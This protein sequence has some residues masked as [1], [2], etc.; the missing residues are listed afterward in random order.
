LLVLIACLSVL[1]KASWAQGATKATDPKSVVLK[2]GN[3]V[4][5][6]VQSNRHVRKV[7]IELPPGSRDGERLPVVFGFHGDGGPAEAYNQRLSP[8][9][10]KH[11][12]ISVSP[13]GETMSKDPNEGSITFFNFIPEKKDWA[14]Q[15][16]DDLGL[17]RQILELLDVHE[18]SNPH[19]IYA[20]G[21]SA[22]GHM[23]NMLAKETDIF[24]AIAPTKC[25][26]VKGM[27]EP[28]E[29]NKR[30][31][32]FWV[33][34]DQ[35][36]SFNGGGSSEFVNLPVSAR[37]ELWRQFNQ[38]DAVAM[39]KSLPEM[40]IETYLAKDGV[41]VTLC[42]LPGIPHAIPRELAQKTD[43]LIIEFFLRHKK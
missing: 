8:Y 12:I 30:T 7:L 1:P 3:N 31:P 21:G 29:G 5:E 26:M 38:C 34:G 13:Q 27:H 9:V 33:M 11:H 40:K 4:V 6:L 18:L 37:I 25:G 42:T 16:A 14:R 23:C 15:Q 10:R 36:K 19:R 22:G 35:D 2:P 20:T 17:V 43:A 39:I 28:T 24:A 41:E 32:L